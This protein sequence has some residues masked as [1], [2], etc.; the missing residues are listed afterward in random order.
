MKGK[1]FTMIGNLYSN[2]NMSQKDKILLHL[3]NNGK[4][5]SHECLELYHFKHLSSVIRYLKKENVKIKS[6]QKYGD[7]QLGERFYWIDY[8]LSPITEQPT[9]IKKII[10]YLK[11]QYNTIDSTI[12]THNFTDNTFQ[13]IY[14]TII[15]LNKQEQNFQTENLQ[16]LNIEAENI[17]N[18]IHAIYQ[19]K[20][21]GL[22]SKEQWQEE[23]ELRQK[24]L[25]S[26][27][28]R[29]EAFDN[30]NNIFMKDV[31]LTLGLLN[32]IHSKY[33]QASDE[34]KVEILKTLLSKCTLNGENISWV[35]KK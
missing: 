8:I 22:I 12:K 21:E 1:N 3:I 11:S 19:D 25:T 29:I 6:V 9:E 7:K 23:N 4:I 16:R 20:L 32:D 24:R 17:R 18:E 34:T 31:N 5:N 10:N 14:D 35:Y 33:L 27:K 28:T 15:N 26:V 13:I 30:T 2:I